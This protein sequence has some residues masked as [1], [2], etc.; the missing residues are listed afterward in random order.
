MWLLSSSRA[1]LHFFPS[2]ESVPEGYAI[3]S[4]VWGPD[5]Q[6]FQSIQALQ[7]S[8]TESGR[9]PRDYVSDKIRECCKLAEQD[10]YDWVWVDTCCIDKTSSA[11]LSEAINSMFRY[12][13]LANVCYAFLADVPTADMAVLTSEKSAFRRSRWHKRGWTL[14]ELLAPAKLL[15]VSGSWE[16]LGSKADLSDVLEQVTRVPADVLL[17]R[18]EFI[19]TSVAQRMSWAAGRVTTRPEDEAYCLMGIFQINMPTLYGEGRRAFR[20]LQQ[21]IM[22]H[23]ADTS[24]FAWGNAPPEALLDLVRAGAYLSLG[25][26]AG[27]EVHNVDTRFLATSPSDFASAA[28]MTCA[29]IDPRGLHYPTAPPSRLA[30]VR[31]MFRAQAPDKSIGPDLPTFEITP[32]GVRAH[33][34]LLKIDRIQVAILFSYQD[35]HHHPHERHLALLLSECPAEQNPLLNSLPLYCIGY[36]IKYRATL[37]TVLLFQPRMALLEGNLKTLRFYGE[38]AR[39]TNIYIRDDPIPNLT[40]SPAKIA[41]C[42][43]AGEEPGVDA[44]RHLL[45]RTLIQSNSHF[46]VGWDSMRRLLG[47]GYSFTLF[48]PREKGTVVL[49][50]KEAAHQA[51]WIVLGKCIHHD[52][53]ADRGPG[54]GLACR[55]WVRL[56]LRPYG[57]DPL[58]FIA[59][60]C[61]DDCIHYS[62]TK[63][64]DSLTFK[65]YDSHQFCSVK[66]SFTP[67]PGL[68][69]VLELHVSEI[70][71]IR[72][73]PEDLLAAVPATLIRQGNVRRLLKKTH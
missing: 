67:A 46:H 20:R 47:Q 1:E 23:Y 21:E 51:I 36:H 6:S 5:E 17:N 8:C 7:K 11:E 28:G 24:L 48:Q 70:R 3:L 69:D 18:E 2:P 73:L 9:N 65:Y 43:R 44:K 58:Q 10:G 38:E 59:H 56:V 42:L 26:S 19:N 64:I 57:A 22:R 29:L 53:D 62:G 50:M 33:I 49:E 15:F 68:N 25:H 66:L 40:V 4:H 71:S 61:E 34:P 37:K 72:P 45:T 41:A 54:E 13:S 52:H 12:Y 31:K 39:W 63:A 16:M 32:Y 35:N 60:H 14:Q 30:S 27:H 55:S